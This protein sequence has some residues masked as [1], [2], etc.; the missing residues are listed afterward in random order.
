MPQTERIRFSVTDGFVVTV[1]TM[2]LLCGVDGTVAVFLCSLLHEC[3]HLLAV[4]LCKGKVLAV[5]CNL[6]GF[7]IESSQV[8]GGYAGELFCLSA[9]ALCNLLTSLLLVYIF[10]ETEY[11]YMLAGANITVGLFNLVP[12]GYFDGGRMLYLCAEYFFGPEHAKSVCRTVSAVSACL[13]FGAGLLLFL[14]SGREPTVL[15]TTLYLSFL[16]GYDIILSFPGRFRR[17]HA[18]A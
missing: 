10:A 11:I 15:L 7:T 14:R 13:V 8:R 18:S 3:A 9:G 6:G 4:L 16:L 1:V 17:R 2:L 5:R 12:C